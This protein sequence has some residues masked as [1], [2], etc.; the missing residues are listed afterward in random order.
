MGHEKPILSELRFGRTL[1]FSA[2]HSRRRLCLPQLRCF[3]PAQSAVTFVRQQDSGR[4][5]RNHAAKNPR[6]RNTESRR[7]PYDFESWS[8]RNVFLVPEFAFS[9]SAIEKRKP[10][11][12][13]ARRAGWIGCNILLKEIPSD[14]R[15]PL[16]T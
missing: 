15:I 5:I 1:L 2:K 9:I 8:V 7:S 12:P 11:A 16:V 3:I 13:T 6:R 10:L 4:R 14:A